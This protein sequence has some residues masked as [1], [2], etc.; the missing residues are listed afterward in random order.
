M[1][2]SW[3]FQDRVPKLG[4]WEPAKSEPAPRRGFI[5]LLATKLCFKSRQAE[6][7]W[8]ALPSWSLGTRQIGARASA[9]LIL[10]IEIKPRR[11]AC[12]ENI[13]FRGLPPPEPPPSRLAVCL[14]AV[15]VKRKNVK[16]KKERILAHYGNITRNPP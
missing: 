9:R 1:T 2:G 3:S 10:R 4:A 14:F 16:K 8:Q 11:G 7:G 6:L 15:F 5:G 13:A 12:S